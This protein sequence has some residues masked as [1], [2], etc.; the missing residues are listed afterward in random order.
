MKETNP[1]IMKIKI[2]PKEIIQLYDIMSVLNP[3]K[4]ESAITLPHPAP[5]ACRAII[6]VE[7]LPIAKCSESSVIYL[8]SPRRAPGRKRKRTKHTKRSTRVPITM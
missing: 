4:L 5:N 3:L 8:F 6:N 7:T 1:N 2:C